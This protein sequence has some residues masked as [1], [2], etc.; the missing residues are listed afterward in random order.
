MAKH[1]GTR[2][3][4]VFVGWAERAASRCLS[5][6][7][8]AMWAG[9]IRPMSSELDCRN[10]DVESFNGLMNKLQ[11]L[12]AISSTNTAKRFHGIRDCHGSK[13]TDK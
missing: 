7:R 3:L 9:P 5:H 8:L 11:Y 12:E 13:S 4:R 6:S 2:D 10:E 1:L